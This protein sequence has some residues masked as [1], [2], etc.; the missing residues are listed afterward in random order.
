MKKK[1]QVNTSNLYISWKHIRRN[2]IIDKI[3]L[4]VSIGSKYFHLQGLDINS[5]HANKNIFEKMM[6]FSGLFSSRKVTLKIKFFKIQIPLVMS[7]LKQKIKK[8]C[9]FLLWNACQLLF[10][11]LG[12][13]LTTQPKLVLFF[14]KCLSIMC[15]S[16]YWNNFLC[17]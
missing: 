2:D 5:F 8:S 17:I 1:S 4:I 6:I 15:S 3:Y 16:A 9:I 13:N 7:I 12:E 14:S 10:N 11:P